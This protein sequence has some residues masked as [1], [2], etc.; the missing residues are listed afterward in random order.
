MPFLAVLVAIVVAIACNLIS[1]LM[2]TKFDAPPFIATLAVQ[3]MAE[4]RRFSIRE[5][6]TFTE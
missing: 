3:A 4:A 1:A 5:V 6:Q 2:V